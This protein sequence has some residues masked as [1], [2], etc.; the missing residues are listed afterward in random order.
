MDSSDRIH[1]ILVIEDPSFTREIHLDAATYSLGRHSS[2]DIVLSCQ[3][4]SR[5]HAT[6]LRRTDVKTNQCSYW[7]LDGDL[8]GN[9]S[10]NGI[11]INGKKSLVHELKPGDLVQFSGDALARY[12]VS[13]Q[14][15]NNALESKSFRHISQAEDTSINKETM[16][17]LAK[18]ES[19]IKPLE[20]SQQTALTEL[21]PQAIIETDLS[22]NI[23]YINSA[24]VVNF[25][26]IHHQKLT[27]PLLKNLVAQERD[28][29][30][31]NNLTIREVRVDNKTFRQ[32]AHYLP[33]KQVIRSY[34]V[35][36]SQEKTLE[37]ELRQNEL[38]HNCITQQITE[39]IIVVESATKQIVE[40][41]PATSELLGYSPAEMLQ[42][43]IYELV[44]ESDKFATILRRVIA[45]KNSFWGEC[46]LRHHNSKLINTKIKIDSI[47]SE[48]EKICLVI[49]H[50]NNYPLDSLQYSGVGWTKE[51]FEQQLLTAIANAKRSQKLLAVMF[52]QLDFLPDVRASIGAKKS[53]KLL[54]TIGERLNAC[55]R[56]GDT[57]IHWQDDKFALLLPQISGIE[58]VAKINQR[59]QKSI[60]QSFTVGETQVTIN[61]TTGIAIYPQDGTDAEILSASAITALKRAGKNKNSF[62][63]YD[64]T[65]NSQALVTLELES[66]LQQALDK[67]EFK[68]YYQPQINVSTG[69]I[70]A[71]EA[72]LRWEHPELGLVAPGNFIKS[73][74]RTKLIVPIGEWAI[75]AA[76]IQYKKWR[77][78]GLS[79]LK[80][81]ISLSLAQF[82]QPNLPQKAAEILAEVGMDASLLELEISAISLMENVDY[83]RSSIERLKSI[84]INLA[85]DGF[86]TGFSVL[87]YLKHFSLDTLKIDRFLVQQLTDSP[88]DLAVVAALI[89]LAKG[90][91]LKVVAEGVE[92]QQ[93]VELLRSLKC[94]NMQGF[95]FGRPLAAEEASKL[96]QLNDSE[97]ASQD[98]IE[99]SEERGSDDGD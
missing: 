55:L 21:S 87:E 17:S 36:I 98:I 79:P 5:N 81:R 90:F 18:K 73:A 86:I 7:I 92:T 44:A 29:E 40:V 94:Y 83:S 38:L 24:G 32:T 2:N 43:N 26:N 34:I 78:Q 85:V 72:L 27:H 96:V 71:I 62:Q 6:L 54:S 20:S 58:E 67:E 75:R 46:C 61:S 41:N 45:D 74:E 59:I 8:Q 64:E 33:E 30:G 10:R 76:C 52:C 39:G 14:L 25:K 66:L 60:A 12:K 53:N 68:L 31:N 9:R 19:R 97:E 15:P 47:G 4:T 69:K 48:S 63:F 99:T 16:V 1:H 35:D 93:Q 80:I 49:H 95:W 77:S 42:M 57:V 65:M 3:K 50:I 28:S 11:Y 70:E 23:T 56:A 37:T 82:Q 13:S 89:E 91:D 88:Q 51:I 84:G 22:G